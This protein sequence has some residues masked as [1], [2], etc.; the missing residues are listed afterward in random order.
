MEGSLARVRRAPELP[1]RPVGKDTNGNTRYFVLTAI[2]NL[3]RKTAKSPNDFKGFGRNAKKIM[4][5]I[6]RGEIENKKITA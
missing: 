4:V 6:D 3:I 5:N 2:K 1:S